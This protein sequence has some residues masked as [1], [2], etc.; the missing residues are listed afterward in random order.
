MKTLIEETCS[1]SVVDNRPKKFE[2]F[3]LQF[4]MHCVTFQWF[5]IKSTFTFTISFFYRNHF[6]LQKIRHFLIF[7]HIQRMWNTEIS[8]SLI[9][10]RS[11]ILFSFIMDVKISLQK[12]MVYPTPVINNYFASKDQHMMLCCS[13]LFV[14]EYYEERPGLEDLKSDAIEV[15]G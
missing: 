14:I 1:D 9:N 8:L 6:F 15:V 12:N 13:W 10:V 3:L 5:T 2:L 11:Q 4:M 7:W